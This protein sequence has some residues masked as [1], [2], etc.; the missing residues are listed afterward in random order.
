MRVRIVIDSQQLDIHKKNIRNVATGCL[1]FNETLL[2]L[3]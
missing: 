2:H 3:L 1:F